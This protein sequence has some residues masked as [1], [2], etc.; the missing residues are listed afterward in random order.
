[1]HQLATNVLWYDNNQQITP[2]LIVATLYHLLQKPIFRIGFGVRTE[3]PTPSSLWAVRPE[4]HHQRLESVGPGKNG[5]AALLSQALSSREAYPFGKNV[6]WQLSSENGNPFDLY[7]GRFRHNLSN[8]SLLHPRDI[9]S[10][11]L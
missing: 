7:T 3:T 8:D 5:G 4:I 1:M 10:G 6:F 11:R 9:P 2:Q